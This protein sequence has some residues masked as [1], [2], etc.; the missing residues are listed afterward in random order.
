MW[1]VVF[2]R[3]TSAQAGQISSKIS[4]PLGETIKDLPTFIATILD[5][6]VN[7]GLPIAIFFIVYAGFLFVTARGNESKLETAKL[8]FLYSIIGTAILL[9]AKLLAVV[10]AGTIA[11]LK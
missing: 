6:V 10:I 8:A 1:I 11:S 2:P 3:S 4:N 7:I 9:A 5:I